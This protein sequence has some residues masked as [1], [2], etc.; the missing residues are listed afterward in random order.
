M[1]T[2]IIVS[3]RFQAVPRDMWP[4]AEEADVKGWGGEV[5]GVVRIR[6]F[7]RDCP[8][9]L[10]RVIWARSA[11]GP[12]PYD[13]YEYWAPRGMA[14]DVKDP[15]SAYSRSKRTQD[16]IKSGLPLIGRRPHG[17]KQDWNA[18][19]PLGRWEMGGDKYGLDDTPL[20]VDCTAC[21]RTIR[22]TRTDVQAYFASLPQR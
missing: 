9:D 15:G 2:R 14:K 20:S 12:S 18:R 16:R 6:C 19:A 22:F 1:A 5:A 10:G 11:E 13:W 3:P 8:S 17:G 7:M 21:P 4:S